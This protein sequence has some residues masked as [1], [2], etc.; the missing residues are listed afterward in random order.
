MARDPCVALMKCALCSST[1]L[2]ALVFETLHKPST[3]MFE[4]RV[5][6][7]QGRNRTMKVHS[8]VMAQQARQTLSSNPRGRSWEFHGPRVPH[9]PPAS[10]LVFPFKQMSITSDEPGADQHEPITSQQYCAGPQEAPN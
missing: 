4:D 2:G 7:Y 6:L 1:K 3:A 9:I 8:P 10:A 5:P